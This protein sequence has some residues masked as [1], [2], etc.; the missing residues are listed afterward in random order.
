MIEK[1]KDYF[2]DKYY[3]YITNREFNQKDPLFT[4]Q[5]F[6]TISL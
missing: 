6:R 3:D 1:I 2:I 4:F 5:Y